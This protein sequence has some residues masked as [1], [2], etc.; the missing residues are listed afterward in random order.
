VYLGVHVQLAAAPLGKP[1]VLE[2]FGSTWWC[3]PAHA[4]P[5]VLCVC[6]CVRACVRACVCVCVCVVC[7]V[8]G[9]LVGVVCVLRNSA[10][11]GGA[12]G[13]GRKRAR[14]RAAVHACAVCVSCA[15][16]AECFFARVGVSVTPTL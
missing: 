6:A 2:E 12:R 16:G 4:P 3:A 14:G 9:V 5:R 8:L 1:L 7:C 13:G 15:L 10:A 11:P